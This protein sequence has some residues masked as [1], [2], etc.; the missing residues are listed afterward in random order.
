V[1]ILLDADDDCAAQL[2]ANLLERAR[3]ATSLPVGAVFAVREYEAWLLA[4]I[5]SLRGSRGIAVDASAPADPESP[6]D[7]K[8]RLTAVM[9]GSRRYVAVADQAA[10]TAA[11]DLSLVADRSRSF[12]KLRS[13]LLRLVAAIRAP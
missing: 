4:A 7:A 12:R 8:G 3:S 6:R 5:E 10:L 1:L 11:V 2:G 13:D 9:N